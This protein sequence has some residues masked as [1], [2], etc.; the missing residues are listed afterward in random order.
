MEIQNAFIGKKEQ[1]SPEEVAAALGSAAGLWN[2]LIAWM[3]DTLGVATQ[4][5]KGI[6]VHSTAG[7]SRSS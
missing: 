7:L 3:A 5:W 2:D 6:Y 1:P 4:E